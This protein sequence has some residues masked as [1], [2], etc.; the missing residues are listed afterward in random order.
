MAGLR[1]GSLFVRIAI[2]I[3]L[4]CLA[5]LFLAAG[6]MSRKYT[7]VPDASSSTRP[8]VALLPT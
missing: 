7:E 2:L 1:R 3:L 6:I 8:A 5:V 4:V